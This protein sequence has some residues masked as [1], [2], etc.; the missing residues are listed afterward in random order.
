MYFY[1]D[2][3]L[4]TMSKPSQNKYKHIFQNPN[5]KRKKSNAKYKNATE[6]LVRILKRMKKEG[7][8][9][10]LINEKA[11]A[12]KKIKFLGISDAQITAALESKGLKDLVANT[13][14]S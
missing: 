11:R 12:L 8:T 1:F 3:L 6:T 13:Y 10:L 5:I 4:L 9:K 14:H 2:V 7:E